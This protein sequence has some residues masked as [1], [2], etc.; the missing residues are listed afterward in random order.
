MQNYFPKHF[1]EIVVQ[2]NNHKHRADILIDDI[3][4]EFQH[5]PIS[6]SEFNDRNVFFKKAGYRLAWVFDLSE[7]YGSEN[8]YFQEYR[9]LDYLMHWKHPKKIFSNIRY[10]SD[11]NKDF[12]LWFAYKDDDSDLFLLDKVIWS[13]INEY[14]ERILNR[15]I[16]SQHIK[17]MNYEFNPQE[18]FYTKEDNFKVALRQLKT[19]FPYEIKYKGVKEHRAIEYTCP[20]NKKFGIKLSSEGGCFYCQ[21]CYMAVLK[22]RED[23]SKW[24]IYCTYPNQS[25]KLCNYMH[26]GYECDKV[27]IY[28]I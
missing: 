18:L 15:F 14:G 23:T 11:S 27:Y 9:T 25:R 22:K 4:I 24:A 7:Q 26:P 16:V 12:A 17:T 13:P 20:R 3:V 5:S 28:S 6:I 2:H 10:L 19:K 21:Y 1:H 8:I